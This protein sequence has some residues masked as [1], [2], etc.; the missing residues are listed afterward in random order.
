M[1]FSNSCEEES[2][3]L[4]QS[5]LLARLNRTYHCIHFRR[6]TVSGHSSASLPVFWNQKL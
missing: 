5:C 4:S 6:G 1:E 3:Q 2:E